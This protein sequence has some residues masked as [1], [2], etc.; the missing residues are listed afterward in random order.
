[1]AHSKR[2]LGTITTFSAA[3]LVAAFMGG[4]GKAGASTAQPAASA[5]PSQ[6]FV[7]RLVEITAGP[8]GYSPA[9]VDAKAGEQLTLRVT[10]K[11]KSECLGEI[12]IPSLDVKKSLP[13]DTPVDIPIKVEKA[14]EIPFSCG[15]KMIFGKIKAS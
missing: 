15:M 14:G 6:P 5:A 3:L 11:T 1:M 12:L 10:R 2:T 8:E 9:V 13:L 7:G 4:C